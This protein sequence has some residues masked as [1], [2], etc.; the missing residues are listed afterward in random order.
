MTP[1]QTIYTHLA[2]K[3][4]FGDWTG[5]D[6]STQPA[7]QVQMRLLKEDVAQSNERILLIKQVSNGGGT[8]YA[9]DPVFVFAVMGKVNEPEVFAETYANLVYE[10]LLDFDH[11]N[12]IISMEPLGAVNGAYLMASGRPVYDTEWRVNVDNGR[13]QL[14]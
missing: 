8:R 4:L 9:T 2:N 10:A 3:G 13:V 11:A 14:G 6:N 7:P 5:P 12:C 1:I